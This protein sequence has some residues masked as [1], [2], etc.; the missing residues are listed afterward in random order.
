MDN[1]ICQ[2]C[3]MPMKNDGD[4]GT[5]RDGTKN[6][7]YCQFCFKDGRFTDEGITMDQKIDKLVTIAKEQMNMSEDEARLIAEN[8]IPK[9]KRWHK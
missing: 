8:T 4:F 1:I 3:G 7:E 2:S 5:N 6:N 9:L